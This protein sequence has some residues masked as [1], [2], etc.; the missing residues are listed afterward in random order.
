LTWTASQNGKAP[1]RKLQTEKSQA[2]NNRSK[3]KAAKAETPASARLDGFVCFPRYLEFEIWF[4][5]SL[6]FRREAPNEK[7]QAPNNRS[8]KK[9][10]TPASARLDLLV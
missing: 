1:E 9:A 7:S 6:F 4:D 3:K 2:P 8:K 5:W 10:E